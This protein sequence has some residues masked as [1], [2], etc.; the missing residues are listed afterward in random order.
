MMP[1]KYLLLEPKSLVQ[2]SIV[3]IRQK[4][5][6]PDNNLEHNLVG[7]IDSLSSK[8]L[9]QHSQFNF[10]FLP[11]E[12]VGSLYENISKDEN[13]STN[14]YSRGAKCD[15]YLLKTS[16]IEKVN[17]LNQNN[18][19]GNL[20][21]IVSKD[22]SVLNLQ[23]S[24]RESING[25]SK[26]LNN[27]FNLLLLENYE[28]NDVQIKKIGSIKINNEFLKSYTFYSKMGQTDLKGPWIKFSDS[29]LDQKIK[30]NGSLSNY[31]KRIQNLQLFSENL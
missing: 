28:S 7:S 18:Y 5:Y 14:S 2:K 24:K 9:T 22:D 11:I 31:S 1:E 30:C 13:I 19:S 25:S 29:K 17:Q 10:K 6:D 27:N 3:A 15:I 4:K 26:F 12:I 23:K 8:D 16:I 21:Y 20:A